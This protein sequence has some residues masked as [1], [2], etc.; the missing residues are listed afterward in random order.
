MC[1]VSSKGMSSLEQTWGRCGRAT[2][3]PH[4][5]PPAHT[6]PMSFP[7]KASAHVHRLCRVW[8]FTKHRAELQWA[9]LPSHTPGTTAESAKVVPHITYIKCICSKWQPTVILSIYPLVF[10]D[11]R[12]KCWPYT[13][14]CTGS[15]LLLKNLALPYHDINQ[16]WANK[17]IRFLN[18]ILNQLSPRK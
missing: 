15:G 2:W 6:Q 4:Q 12:M 7:S 10:R 1:L 14:R 16:H 13:A 8:A 17:H 18:S 5:G 3:S 11:Q 9:V